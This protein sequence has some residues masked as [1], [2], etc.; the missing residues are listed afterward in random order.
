MAS[1]RP[2]LLKSSR[3]R[4]VSALSHYILLSYGLCLLTGSNAA[5]AALLH[6][7]WLLQ[8]AYIYSFAVKRSS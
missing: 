3:P 7:S 2:S 6:I 1:F 4:V 8:A 5:S